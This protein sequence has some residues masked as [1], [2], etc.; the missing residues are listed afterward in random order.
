MKDLSKTTLFMQT[1]NMAWKK[2]SHTQYTSRHGE[3]ELDLVL[4]RAEL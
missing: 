1:R 4:L 3:V 2:C